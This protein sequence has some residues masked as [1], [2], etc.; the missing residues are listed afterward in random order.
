[1]QV[2]ACQ[3]SALCLSEQSEQLS[4][5]VCLS[6]AYNACVAEELLICSDEVTLA[7]ALR[8]ELAVL[9]VRLG[10]LTMHVTV[11]AGTHETTRHG[12]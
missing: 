2:T 6:C 10:S 1:M 8:L 9:L 4:V 11:R 3:Q 12:E 7:C 5:H